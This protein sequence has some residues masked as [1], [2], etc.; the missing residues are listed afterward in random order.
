MLFRKVIVLVCSNKIRSEALQ[1][2][3]KVPRL[4]IAIISFSS[5]DFSG[6]GLGRGRTSSVLAFFERGDFFGGTDSRFR[7]NSNRKALT[8]GGRSFRTARSRWLCLGNLVPRDRGDRADRR[9]EPLNCLY[10]FCRA[11]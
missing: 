3:G 1:I 4:G 8:C 2:L 11:G 9:P 7:N 10:R 6:N 5:R